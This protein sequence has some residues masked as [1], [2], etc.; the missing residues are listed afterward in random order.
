MIRSKNDLKEYLN[1]DNKFHWHKSHSIKYLRISKDPYYYI[2]KYL[3]LLRKEEYYINNI[4]KNKLNILL[5][6]IYTRK[7]N[8][9]GNKIGLCIP[10]NCVGKG[11]TIYHPNIIIN[12]NSKIGDYCIFHGNNCIGNNGNDIEAP[13]IGNNVDIGYSANII[14]N[15]K[16]NSN[17]TI[18]AN[19]VVVNDFLKSYDTIVGVPAKSIKKVK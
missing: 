8:D 9:I 13:V 15:V 17:I 19:A 2:W 4:S 14:G 6:F 12:A 10:P 5:S 7:K 16:I 11:V 1:E 18:G 3:V